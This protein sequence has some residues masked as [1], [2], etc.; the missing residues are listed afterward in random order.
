MRKSWL[1]S[2]R[3]CLKGLGAALALPLLETMGWAD[4]PKG[5]AYK[6]PVRLGFMYMP[7]GVWRADFWPAD[8]KTFP[9]VL[10]KSLE[11]LRPVIDQCLILD[12]LDNVGHGPV[13]NAA[14][15]LELSCWLTAT[16]LN[17]ENRANIDI[18]TSIDQIAAKHI[19]LY[20]VLPSL[21]L[22]YQN[23]DATGTGQ[24]GV[25]NRYYTTGNYGSPTQPLPVE[26]NPASVYKRLFSSRQSTPRK[27]G[28]PSVDTAKFA[29]GGAPS[30]DGQSL[31]RSMLDLVLNGAKDLRG[32]VSIDDQR[33]LDEYL[34]T[35][36][37]LES[38]VAAIERQQAEAA[39]AKASGKS[40]AK[41]DFKSS[42]PIEVKVP[43]GG[44]KWSEHIKVMGDLMILAFQTDLTRVCSLTASH[45]QGI[46][47][48][49]LGFSDHHHDCSHHGNDQDKIAKVAKIDRFN[50]E[51]F[52]YIVTR[53][54]SLR[55]GPDTLLD[56]CIMMWGSGQ[57]DG[58]SH[59]NRRLPTIL[60]GRGGGT[61]R[62]GRYVPKCNGNHG[63]LL[64]AILA[65][66]GVPI[67]K[68]IGI[69]TKLLPD[70]S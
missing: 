17:T 29:G 55:E 43:S 65:R 57:E 62:T 2:R 18:A 36:R 56:N 30:D 5:G 46:N 34:D 22:A 58:D 8:A 61:I 35:V 70:L 69:G 33:R 25:N 21:E 59:S 54:K 67:E 27:R 20:T 49:E 60:A 40:G 44:V 12:G 23:N 63:D 4:A 42:D 53:M 11:P 51:Q 47:Y 13:G 1:I 28:G 31:D 39:K 7:C 26:T 38:R 64:T 14:H 19:G 50:I 52:A 68:P 41:A 32:R 66:A 45:P 37:S 16:L 10:P 3:T 15:A 9:V 6:P 24:E 48:P